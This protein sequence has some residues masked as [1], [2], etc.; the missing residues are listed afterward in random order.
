MAEPQMIDVGQGHIC[1]LVLVLDG[2]QLRY[3]LDWK[4]QQLSDDQKYTVLE[5]IDRIFAGTNPPYRRMYDELSRAAEV[6]WEVERVGREHVVDALKALKEARIAVE[7]S[8][9]PDQ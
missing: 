3:R 9:L 4:Q 6:G 1:Q 7:V 2:D 5:A 8:A